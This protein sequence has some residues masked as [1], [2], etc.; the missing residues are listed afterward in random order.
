[1]GRHAAHQLDL[2]SSSA[3]YN[4]FQFSLSVLAKTQNLWQKH[5]DLEEQ[6]TA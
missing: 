2:S 3:L 4:P 5:L 6:G 1:M